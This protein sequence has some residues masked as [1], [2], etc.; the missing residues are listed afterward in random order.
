MHL[1]CHLPYATSPLYSPVHKLLSGPHQPH[2]PHATSPS[3]SPVHS[4]LRGPGPHQLPPCLWSA[5]AQAAPAGSEAAAAGT[6]LA[7]AGTT[8]APAS[9][10]AAARVMMWQLYQ[11]PEG[12]AEQV[13]GSMVYSSLQTHFAA[14]GTAGFPLVL[15]VT[16]ESHGE[17]NLHMQGLVGVSYVMSYAIWTSTLLCPNKPLYNCIQ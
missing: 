5:G 17:T 2:L 6:D 13:T 14:W 1:I 9:Q 16:I 8:A 7:A 10:E 4:L 12:I 3:Y 15:N 11:P